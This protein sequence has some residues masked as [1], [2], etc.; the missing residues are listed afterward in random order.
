VNFRFDLHL[1]A[2]L[3]LF[4]AGFLAVI[5]VFALIRGEPLLPYAGSVAI[6]GVGGGVLLAAT[7]GSNHRIRPRD[8]LLVVSG[9]WIVTSAIG[10]LPFVLAGALGPVD[11]LFESV[12]GFTTTGSTVIADVTPL[13]R[14]LLLWRAMTQWIGGMGIILFTIA[15]LP[16]LGIGGMQ[17]FQAEVPGPVA[18]KVQ[19]RLAS[20]ARTLWAIYV[21]MTA[22]EVL[23]LF[24]C[25]MSV[26][27]AVCH[28][29]TTMATGGFST[30][31]TSV[32]EFGLPAAEWVITVFMLLAGV[33]FVLHYRALTGRWRVALRDAELR[34]F[35]G[36][37]ATAT[38]VIAFTLIRPGAGVEEVL[39]TAAFQV[40]S[41]ITTTG[42]ATVDF[43]LWTPLAHVVLLALM[44]AGGM[45]GSTGGGVKSMRVLISVRALRA[46]IHRLI[47]PHAVR[48]VKYNGQVVDD[49]ILSEVWA[50][51]TAYAFIAL[52]ATALI[53]ACGY[54]LVTSGSAALTTLGNVGP[55]LG[56]IGAYD[57]FSHFPTIPKLVMSACMLLGRLEIFTILALFSREFWRR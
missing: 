34:Y 54:D 37:V 29:F 1:I 11:A 28:A 35:L 43:E 3:A 30:R 31:N 8:G 17:L 16:L 41:I 25:G 7:R 5:A 51:L 32:G 39:R 57:N 40:A 46:T 19:P 50:F 55:G 24:A 22:A 9:G 56:A 13:P 44:V 15:I 12:S 21:G 6:A 33:N 2:W 18:D 14:A 38:A 20:T 48:P 47:H 52:V 4:N 42:Y 27:D 53:A 49:S 45:A 36:L 23:A 26:Y 10:A